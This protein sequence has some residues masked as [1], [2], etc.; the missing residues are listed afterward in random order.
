MTN[1]HFVA[2]VVV[3]L[4]IGAPANAQ[5]AA[6]LLQKGIHAQETVGDVDSAI[7]IF[8]QVAASPAANKVLAAQAQYQLV[9]CMLQ[10]GDR[11][12]A[13]KE[14]DLLARNF[15]DQSDLVTKARKLV[16]GGD[17]LLPAPWGELE[18]SQ[19]NIKRDGV[20]TG[21][22]LHYSVDPAFSRPGQPANPQTVIL[23]WE[24]TTTKT[25]RSAQVE[26]DRDSQR[27]LAKPELHS[28]DDLGDPVAAAISGPAIDIE[29]SVFLMRRLPLAPGFKTKLNTLPFT[30]ASKVKSPVEITVTGIEAVQ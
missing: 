11:A 23:R 26:V 21:E 12:A 9:V 10:K 13:R 8:R 2:A 17:T 16:P 30:L 4:L 22:Y 27:P 29:E 18:G 1:Q 28:N 20:F 14:L 3:V 19:L 5:S 7:Q 24:L 6:D 25:N 15:P